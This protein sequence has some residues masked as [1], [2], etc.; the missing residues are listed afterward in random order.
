[1][2][3]KLEPG[4]FAGVKK[5][6]SGMAE[7]DMKTIKKDMEKIRENIRQEKLAG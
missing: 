7:S 6:M 5:T 4:Y 3:S 2:V 1:M